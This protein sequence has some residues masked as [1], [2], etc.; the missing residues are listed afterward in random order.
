MSNISN[1]GGI[2]FSF[3]AEE[4]GNMSVEDAAVAI[5][6]NKASLMDK[7]VRGDIEAMQDKNAK[8]KKAN[9]MLA[10]ARAAFGSVDDDDDAKLPSEVKDFMEDNGIEIP[11]HS[12]ELEKAGRDAV[13]NNLQGYTQQFTDENQLETT[14]FQQVLGKQQR[15]NEMVS[16]VLQKMSEGLNAR[17]KDLGR[18]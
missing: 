14:K 15:A 4:L 1:V 17:A 2:S 6:A 8:L 11:K 12:S 13:V 16:Q 10:K 3:S 9:D 5:L 18:A 7:K